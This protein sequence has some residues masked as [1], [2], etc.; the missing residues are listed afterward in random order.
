M[1]VVTRKIGE[2][3]VINLTRQTLLDLLHKYPTSDSSPK[4]GLRIQ[5]EVMEDTKPQRV[6]LGIE[7]DRIIPINRGEVQ[8]LIDREEKQCPTNPT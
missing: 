5:V 4:G 6:R 3:V 8:D 7:A 2:T 1:L